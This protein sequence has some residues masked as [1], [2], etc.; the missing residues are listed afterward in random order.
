LA[1]NKEFGCADLRVG[2][3]KLSNLHCNFLENLDKQSFL[4]MQKI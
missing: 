3:I 4:K 1:I 2:G